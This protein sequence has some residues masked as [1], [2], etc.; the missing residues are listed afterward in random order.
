MRYMRKVSNRQRQILELLLSRQGEITVG[1]IADEIRVSTRTIHRE[2]PEIEAILHNEGMSLSK[3][4]GVGI[5]IQAEPEQLEALARRLARLDTRAYGTDERKV[6]ILCRLLDASE[7]MKLYTL[8]HDLRVTEPTISADLDEHEEWLGKQGLTLV[9]RRGYGIQVV[10]PETAKRSVIARLARDYLDDSELFGRPS[11]P[12]PNPV[13]RMLLEM[14]GKDNFFQVEQAVWQL[15]ERWPS[16]LSETAYT[17]LLIRLSVAITRMKQG[18]S[19][20]PGEYAARSQNDPEAT[21]RLEV[22][23]QK[24]DLRLSPEE[25][26]YFA[27]LLS[28]WEKAQPNEMLLHAD[29]DLVETV[30]NLIRFVE[31]RIHIPLLQDRSLVEGLLHHMEP[32]LQRIEQGDGIRNPLITQIKRDFE[33]LFVTVREAV[34]ELIEGLQVPDEEIGYLVMH[35]GAALERAKQFSRNVRALIVCTSG[36]GSSK[37]LAARITKELPQIEIVG[38]TSWFEAAHRPKE[39]YDLIISTVD[40]PVEA[41]QY[42]KL[43]PLLTRDETE[44]L[45]QF[46]QKIL[47]TRTASKQQG[48]LRS[49]GAADRL[50]TLRLYAREMAGLLERFEVYRLDGPR[51]SDALREIMTKIC[52]KVQHACGLEQV[53]PVVSQLLARESYGSQV[54]PDTELALMHTRSDSVKEPLVA[55]FVVNPPLYMGPDHRHAVEQI[56]LMLAPMNLPRESLEVLSEI[57][58][59]LLLP[60]FIDQLKTADREG[61][62]ESMAEHLEQFIQT[63]MEW[64]ETI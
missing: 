16:Q 7:P 59:M 26:D 11:E 49:G 9:R 42:V 48:K 8:S 34:D 18:R 35:F 37:L 58:A 46:I 36:I 64:R 54:I 28:S 14:I 6:L 40:L 27:D 21:S 45:R 5:Q 33:S 56:L 43:S 53:E 38:Q 44:R 2:L 51:G 13:T 15:E 24:L 30:V 31:K 20:K 22:F 62:R 23:I 60:E 47:V 63:K 52:T 32:A 57:S 19:I 4:S 1:E 41:D 3:K 29:V 61:I 10:G 12:S 55:L 50:R 39:E 17:E 25:S